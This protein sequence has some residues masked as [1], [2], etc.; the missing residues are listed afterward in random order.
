[1]KKNLLFLNF[2]VSFLFL[3]FFGTSLVNA[4]IT[5]QP[6]SVTVCAGSSSISFAVKT[7]W[8]TPDLQW[9]VL[10]GKAW[11]N[12]SEQTD[13]FAGITATGTK[14]SRITFG[15]SKAYP[16]TTS[17]SGT[18]VRCVNVFKL[19]P[20]YSSAAVATVV[21]APTITNNPS[22]AEVL[23]DQP[24]TFSVIASGSGLSYQWQLDQGAGF[25]NISGAT[26]ASHTIKYALLSD[27]GTYRCMVTNGI[28]TAKY[29][30]GAVLSV[31]N[32]L[33]IDKNPSKK[34][35]CESTTATFSVTAANATGYQWEELPYKSSTWTTISGANASSYT[36]PALTT[37]MNENQYR[38]VVYGGAGQSLTSYSAYL[39]VNTNVA[40][41]LN[42]SNAT[43]VAGESV[44][45]NA[46][47]S[48]SVVSYQ[49]QFNTGNISGATSSSYSIASVQSSNIGSY[50]CVITGACNT[51]TTN[52]ATLNVTVP[53]YPNG[54]KKQTSGSGQNIIALSAVSDLIAWAVT[55]DAD[56]LLK[57]TDGG[58]TWNSIQTLYPSG[59]WRSIFFIS[60]SEGVVGGYN[61]VS[62]T[63]NGG[64]S[65]TYTDLKTQFGLGPSDYFYINSIQFIDALNGWGVGSN[66]VVIKTTDG[67]TTWSR[68]GYKTGLPKVTDVDLYSV[69]FVNSSIGYTG[70]LDGMLLKTTNGGT[71]WT[72][73]SNGAV[74]NN[75]N[76]ITFTSA[77]NGFL[78][79]PNFN[80]SLF[81]TT[82]GGTTW[83]KST[84]PGTNNLISSVDFVDANNGWAAGTYYDFTTS[85]YPALILKTYDGGQTWVRQI[86]DNP[87]EL[88][89]IRMF[90][91][92]HGWTVG[93]SGKIYRTGKGGCYDP[94][95]SLYADQ[96]LCANQ[97][98]NLVADTF[99]NNY[100]S[101]YLWSTGSTLGNI[102]VNSTANYSVTITNECGKTATDN[103]TITFLALPVA[104][105]GEDVAICEGES[106]QLN[107]S[108]GTGYSWNF[109]GYLND[110][111]IANPIA[112]PPTGST[113]FTVTVKD[114][115]NCSSTDAV[116]VT[117]NPIPTSDFSA[118]TFVCG[119]DNASLQ[120]TGTLGTKSF[121]WDLSGGS[122]SGSGAGP[123]NVN[124]TDLGD[125]LVSLVTTENNCSSLP[126]LKVIGVREQPTA[127]F[128][129]PVATC[130][131]NS[132]VL[133][134]TGSAPSDASYSWGIDGGTITTGSGQGPIQVSWAT[135]GNK[136]VSLS[137]TQ[138]ECVSDIAN[139]DLSVAYPFEGEQ[140][141]LVTIDLETG[142]NMVVWEKTHDV[143]IASYN[144]YREG[145]IQNNYDLLGNV[146]FSEISVFV[147]SGS[148]PEQQQYK[149]KISAVDTCGNESSKSKWHKTMF[150]QY[151]SSDNGVN[152]NWQEYG[153]ESGSMSFDS[154]AIF[155]GSDS[156][157][158]AE[159]TTIS[160]SFLAYTDNTPDALSKKLYYR[161][162]GVKANACDPAETLGKK[163][164]SGPFVHSLSNLEDNRLQSGGTGINNALADAMKL[165]VYPS[166]FTDLATISYTLQKSSKMKVEIYNVVG[167]KMGEILNETQVAGTHK[168]EM[169]ASDVNYVGGLY[170]LKISVD[171]NTI[172]KKTMLT[173]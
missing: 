93:K 103:A 165:S 84:V 144:V 39:Y 117:V 8:T 156:T 105:A 40:V 130:G 135:Q 30:S 80:G 57:T 140:I 153:V 53:T 170:Y 106:A 81:S 150:L 145:T 83:T 98:F 132:A 68:L 97:S 151:V 138:N 166:P 163:A 17:F 2:F 162:G 1:M 102:T 70:G 119:T 82:D 55:S 146:P 66:G 9:Q 14:T 92:D 27:A 41:S 6:V 134:Y 94:V 58:T 47:A 26:T 21:S 23:I 125:K 131:D 34:T 171:Q 85:S 115:N 61:G 52:S 169:K 159:L 54:W 96:T 5:S 137:V 120:F 37:S 4:T 76:D 63:T 10:S 152:L 46:S 167:E 45:F 141:C 77:T 86:T 19:I 149:Y 74:T 139:A 136:S 31:Y 36:T 56:Q 78:V 72:D 128:D 113:T 73:I 51:V 114:A 101:R 109:A 50:R 32:I 44:T 7:D 18:Q 122:A 173:R 124:W 107:A 147:D 59:Y 129:A 3:L 33:S 112:T 67:G 22:S 100:N 75:I 121:A 42:P 43:K 158:L 24:A 20:T 95:V 13:P 157:A 172:I 11:V 154:Y 160:A 60:S 127:S 69:W 15:F 88:Y 143:G 155:R 116:K 65:W 99:A 79:Q 29:S 90:S 25:I 148:K 104:N 164:S 118:P 48:G 161:V 89:E 142:K 87:K 91:A 126:T 64:T 16:L 133:I 38:V 110:N 49:W 35:A 168:L 28:C 12:I 62:K 111:L 108:G 71:N 123:F